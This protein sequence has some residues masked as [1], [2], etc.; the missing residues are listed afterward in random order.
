[1]IPFGI[2]GFVEYKGF[3]FSTMISGVGKQDLW[4]NSDVIWPYPSVFDHIY[5]HQL[6]YWTPDN[7]NAFYPRVYGN[8]NG[9]TG[10][11]YSNSR[12]V[13]TKYLSD[14]SYL[15]IQNITIGYTLSSGLLEKV[16]ID[17]FRLFVSGNNL[18]TLD[19]LPKGLNPDQGSNG[20]YPI[21]RNY[22]FGLNA[23]F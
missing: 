4:R 16:G 13:Q 5:K 15:K 19:N 14:E 2:F 12:R 8:P 1:M 7:Q 17:N 21:M 22:S 11:N 20:V 18:F 3:D 23:T 9:N 6:D 10:S